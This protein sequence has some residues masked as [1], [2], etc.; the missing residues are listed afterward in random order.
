[1]TRKYYWKVFASGWMLGDR[2]ISCWDSS[3]WKKNK[4]RTIPNKGKIVQCNNG[5][6]ASPTLYD[7]IGWVRGDFIG[8]VEVAG[9]RSFSD[10]YKLDYSK[11]AVRKMKVKK[12]WRFEKE[13]VEKLV[14]ELKKL[15][16]GKR[17]VANLEFYLHNCWSLQNLMEDLYN[18]NLRNPK[19][20]KFAM[21]LFE[22]II[23]SKPEYEW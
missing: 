8:I 16:R 15:K 2:P 9:E 4:W 11:I 20:R 21:S 10:G 12:L 22:K 7:A 3:I 5:F 17:L 6:H 23:K 13:D 19:T 18:G 1:M 14:K